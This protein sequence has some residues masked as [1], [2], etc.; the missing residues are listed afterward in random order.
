MHRLQRWATWRRIGA[1]SVV[2]RRRRYARRVGLL[3]ALAAG[4]LFVTL[5]VVSSML[6]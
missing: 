3:P 1:D 5:I 6:D 2:E 4:I